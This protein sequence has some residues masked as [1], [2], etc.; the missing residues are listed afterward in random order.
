VASS[1]LILAKAADETAAL[2]K[3]PWAVIVV[4][5]GMTTLVRP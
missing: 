3:V 2:R 5:T 1:V 4:V